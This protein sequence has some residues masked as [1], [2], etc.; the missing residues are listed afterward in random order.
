VHRHPPDE[1]AGGGK[2]G[3]VGSPQYLESFSGLEVL[4]VGDV[5]LDS[6][7]YGATTGICREAPIPVVAVDRRSSA[8]GG[9][10]NTAVNIAALGARTTLLSVTG[11]DDDGA[12][13][14]RVLRGHGLADSDVLLDSGRRTLAKRR[15]LAG[16]QML[17]RFDEGGRRPLPAAV[18]AE[19][20]R[21]L[22]LRAAD[23]DVVVV[24]DYGYGVLGRRAI[25][26]L[27]EL[28]RARP[29]VLVVDAR[30]LGRYREV[31]A[32]A[33]KPNFDEVRPFLPP[34]AATGA[35]R[36]AAVVAASAQLPAATGAGLVAVTL[37]RDG[38]VLCERG[39]P[40]YRTY[41][42]PMPNRR[43]SGAGDS[44]T[45]ALALALAAGADVP[46]AAEMA[47][48]AAAVVV[49]R[50]GT[51][52]CSAA[53]LREHLYDGAP[54]LEDWSR[55]ADRVAFQ[56]RQG[57]RMVFTNG[58][59]DLL[60]RGHI[61]FLNHAKSLGDVL[62]VAL[63]S[64]ASMAR[65]KGPGRPVNRLEDRAGVL[66]ALSCV[67]HLASFD[68]DTA[69]ELVELLRPD[70]YAKGGDYTR[71]MVPEAP[72]VERLGGTVRI[73]PYLE[74]RSTSAIIERVRA[75]PDRPIVP[76][77]VVNLAEPVYDERAR[78]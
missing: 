5:I 51:S 75:M 28:Q 42:R 27:A 50:D 72:L 74:D 46:A 58:C 62:V 19:L 26:A 14:R 37:D 69:A 49:G 32:T 8:A 59:F 12:Q 57:R 33:V 18:D 6:Y 36:V 47:A 7:L 16:D 23:C 70:V 45:A 25:A 66:A 77:Q 64:D 1:V 24:S 38:A 63:N 30:S 22:L 54:R 20:R 52:A 41:T 71:A 21:R 67:D 35:G 15:L 68:A 34:G 4:V 10:G 61:D 31:G 60:H 73:L 13:L 29:R 2:R 39:R 65:I 56:R 17:A 11:E 53:D 3:T 43:A 76:L 9:A 78:P 40:A 48:A 55:L 44:F